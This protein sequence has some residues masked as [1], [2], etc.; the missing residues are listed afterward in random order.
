MDKKRVS[1]FIALLVVFGVSFLLLFSDIVLQPAPPRIYHISMLA[2]GKNAA[3]WASIREGATLAADE[4]NAE[5]SFI[6][7]GDDNNAAQQEA[8]LKRESEAGVDALLLSAADS[9]ALGDILKA[10]DLKTPVICFESPAEGFPYVSADNRAMGVR[11]GRQLA[12]DGQPVRLALV[13]SGMACRHIQERREGLLSVLEQAGVQPAYWTLPADSD[14]VPG[15]LVQK[16]TPR[17]AD[18]LVALDSI[19]LEQTAQMAA[20][21]G[22][23]GVPSLYGIGATD[24]VLSYL[25]QGTIS[26]IVVQNDFAMGYLSVQAAMEAIKGHPPAQDIPVEFRIVTGK[27]M[28]DQANQPLLFPFIR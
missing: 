28:Y 25:E 13:E 7:L 26:A 14:E 9:Q 2:R 24:K 4:S 19:S 11:L 21:T 17:D 6:L 23:P 27:T 10:L 1:I 16:L 12:A 3:A 5:L 8:L 15:Y 18:V 20:D 22:K